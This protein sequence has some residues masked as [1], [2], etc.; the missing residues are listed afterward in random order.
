MTGVA[1]VLA[2]VMRMLRIVRRGGRLAE[3]FGGADAHEGH[4]VSGLDLVLSGACLDGVWFRKQ[5]EH[6]AD[7][8]S[9]LNALLSSSMSH[10]AVI[11]SLASRQLQ[12]FNRCASVLAER[13]ADV[14]ADRRREGRRSQLAAQRQ[15]WPLVVAA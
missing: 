5:L 8:S 14:V 11:F 9:R 12:P 10:V 7:Q 1:R 4:H 13:C 15:A 2:F 3:D 6:H